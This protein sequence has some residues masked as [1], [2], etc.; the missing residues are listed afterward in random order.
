[1][2]KYVPPALRNRQQIPVAVEATREV[3]IIQ[4]PTEITTVQVIDPSVF[5]AIDGSDSYTYCTWLTL[6]SR[7]IGTFPS[8]IHRGN[9][10]WVRCPGIWLHNLVN[11]LHVKVDTNQRQNLG[12]EFS[13][14]EFPLNQNV[15][16]A[17]VANSNTGHLQLYLNGHL[18]CDYHIADRDGERF[19]PGQDCCFLG[20]DPWH[21]S[22]VCT[23]TDTCVFNAP[24]SVEEIRSVLMRLDGVI[25]LPNALPHLEIPNP[26][27]RGL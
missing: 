10:E 14:S 15:H 16:V 23:Y 25:E 20:K 7:E 6:H 22:S 8:L 4:E 13:R 3:R 27:K 11:Q 2:A 5:T 26:A 18:D 1:M 19:K 17:I 12:I 9:G 24:L 21:G